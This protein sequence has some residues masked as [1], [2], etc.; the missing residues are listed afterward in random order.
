MHRNW[1]LN[2]DAAAQG[3]YAAMGAWLLLLAYCAEHEL[4]VGEPDGNGIGDAKITPFWPWSER[5]LLARIGID[6]AGLRLALEGG[7]CS[8]AGD[9]LIVHGYDIKGERAARA[10]REGG[11]KG[12]AKGASKPPSKAPVKGPGKVREGREGKGKE[13]GDPRVTEVF[14]HWREKMQKNAAAKLTDDRRA[15]VLARLREG[16]TVD[17]IKRAIDGCASSPHH[18]GENE[19]RTRYDDLTL[20]CRSG[21]KLEGFRDRARMPSQAP[22]DPTWREHPELARRR[23]QGAS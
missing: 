23:A 11:S 15:K 8:S 13:R 19:S 6:E 14:E 16:Y 10:M 18:M 22:L 9:G 12:G 20:I 1:L 17:D 5:E 3:N 21:S 2:Q 4:G 7:L